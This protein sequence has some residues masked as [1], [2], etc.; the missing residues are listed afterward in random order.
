MYI[1]PFNKPLKTYTLKDEKK[2]HKKFFP[3]WYSKNRFR[4]IFIC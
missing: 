2:S 4:N 3:T 1:Y